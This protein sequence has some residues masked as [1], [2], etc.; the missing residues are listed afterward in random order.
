MD[1]FE[2]LARAIV[3]KPTAEIPVYPHIVPFAGRR[4]GIT[5]EQLFGPNQ[6]WLDAR[7]KTF[8][9]V[10]PGYEVPI[11]AEADNLAALSGATR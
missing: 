11:T 6:A 8:A 3:P 4:T 1:S 2:K 9:E 7:D 5:Q 10:G